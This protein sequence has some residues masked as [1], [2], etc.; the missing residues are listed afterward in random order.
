MLLN[1][2]AYDLLNDLI[3]YY[4]E[5]LLSWDVAFVQLCKVHLLFHFIGEFHSLPF[6]VLVGV[7]GFEPTITRTQTA[8]L[9]RLDHTP[10]YIMDG[11]QHAD[12]VRIRTSGSKC[13]NTLLLLAIL[14][15]S[16]PS[17]I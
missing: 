16:R 14:R 7:V 3:C 2:K 8:C 6:L 15:Y 1:N 17:I 11:W 12:A 9:A 5:L 10:S 4:W 13:G